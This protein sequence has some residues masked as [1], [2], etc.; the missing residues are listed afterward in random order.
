MGRKA[1]EY[2]WNNTA[3]NASTLKKYNQEFIT[4]KEMDQ[5]GQGKVFSPTKV[6]VI[7]F[8]LLKREK[9]INVIFM[10]PKGD[11]TGTERVGSGQ[12]VDGSKHAFDGAKS[13]VITVLERFPKLK[14]LS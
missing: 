9:L 7:F 4:H 5:R 2:L 10:L 8:Q 13:Q 14:V 11:F 1:D 6:L 3:K 12:G